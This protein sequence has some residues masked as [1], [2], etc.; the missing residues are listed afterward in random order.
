MKILPHTDLAI[1]PNQL[2]WHCDLGLLTKAFRA[3][4]H[5]AY[6]VV[7]LATEP[8]TSPAI[9]NELDYTREQPFEAP[10]EQSEARREVGP[11]SEIRAQARPANA[12]Q[13][14]PVAGALHSSD[15]YSESS[16]VGP[17][18]YLPNIPIEPSA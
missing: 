10:P 15:C 16:E 12:G 7:H 2:S 3:L 9:P 17:P 6:L 14:P 8:R 4:G 13:N 5:E 1:R 11:H 18:S